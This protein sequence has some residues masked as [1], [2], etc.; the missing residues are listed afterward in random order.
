M[1]VRFA[2]SV[3]PDELPAAIICARVLVVADAVALLRHTEQT[4][5]R[6][7]AETARAKQAES[8]KR[9]GVRG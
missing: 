5:W 7:N 3:V 8:G 2:A 6:V 4:R 1:R 9:G